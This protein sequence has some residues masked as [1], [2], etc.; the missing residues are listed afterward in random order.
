MSVLDCSMIQLQFSWRGPSGNYIFLTHSSQILFDSFLADCHLLRPGDLR[1]IGSG[2]G[3]LTARGGVR[4]TPAGRRASPGTAVESRV[5]ED[6]RQIRLH[7]LRTP[8]DYL[9]CHA[10]RP[11]GTGPL[12]GPAAG[13]GTPAPAHPRQQPEADA[14]PA[15]GAG[16]ALVPRP[17]PDPGPGPRPPR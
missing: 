7:T 2:T 11:P 5:E 17:D 1:E 15:G 16:A 13:R 14:P 8:R 4:G 12:P 9:S 3:V 10:R 6:L